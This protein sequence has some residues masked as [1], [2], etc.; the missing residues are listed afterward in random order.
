MIQNKSQLY[1][2]KT[3]N[4]LQVLEAGLEA[5]KPEQFLTK[6]IKRNK[7][8]RPKN[9][10][11]SGFNRI[12]VIAVGKAADS[13]ANYVCSKISIDGGLIVIPQTHKVEHSNEKFKIIRSSHPIPN[14]K[15]VIAAK[16]L[17]RFLQNTNR[18][19]FVIFL[20]SGGTSPLVCLPYGVTLK[21]KQALTQELLTC[22]ATIKEINTLRK[23][24]SAV[25][26]G[27]ILEH[28]NC[29]AVSFVLSDVVDDD[30]SSIASGLTYCDTTTY[31]DCI[32]IIKKY[33]LANKIPKAVLRHF[34]MGVQGK[35]PE[36]PKTPKIPN[37]VVASNK[38]CLAAM[39]KKAKTLGYKTKTL[40]PLSGNI[41]IVAS[42]ILRNLPKSGCLLFGGEPTVKVAGSGR[43]GR[44]QEL[45][46]RLMKK[47]GSEFV[48][49]SVGTDGIDGNTK[50]AGAI[51]YR[52][53]Q[54]NEIERYL[55]NNDSNSF[56]KKY[57]GLIK[58]GPTHTNLMDI[59]LVMRL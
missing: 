8:T 24:L 44:N 43:G 20:I 15:S 46:L 53:I 35:I 29:K 41:R 21:Q 18:D 6:Y 47:L 49:A 4:A 26:G 50:Y 48:V 11:L 39:A 16:S 40:Q 34:R 33:G 23:H 28:L 55:Q 3:K 59:G 52:S 7:I 36:T 9:T 25:K 54:K 2:N 57:G 10:C 13:M 37:Y 56:F 38:D 19:D 22:G 1:D 45:V 17:I 5:A 30:L 12:Y 32:R 51:F 27:K 14:K 31:A 42:K 58:T